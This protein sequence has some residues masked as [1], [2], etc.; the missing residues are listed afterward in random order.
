MRGSDPRGP[1]RAFFRGPRIFVDDDALWRRHAGC[2]NEMRMNAATLVT[3]SPAVGRVDQQLADLVLAEETLLSKPIPSRLMQIV[4]GTPE[5]MAC[6]MADYANRQTGGPADS[7][8]ARQ[9]D[10]I[11]ADWQTFKQAGR[12]IDRWIDKC[13]GCY[14]FWLH[15]SVSFMLSHYKM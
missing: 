10:S 6:L 7:Q 9:T 13:C 4:T 12:Q 2:A 15:R 11:Q 5:R 14:Q 1:A 8:P 3:L